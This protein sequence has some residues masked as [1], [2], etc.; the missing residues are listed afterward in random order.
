MASKFLEDGLQTRDNPASRFS[1][2]LEARDL[3]VLGGGSEV[4]FRAIEEPERGFLFDAR[5]VRVATV[6]GLARTVRGPAAALSLAPPADAVSGVAVAD[7]WFKAA[8]R[9]SGP[10][11]EEVLCHAALL[12]QRA[13]PG[14]RAT[15]RMKVEKRL[16]EI[17]KAGGPGTFL[18]LGRP[19]S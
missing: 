11:K 6:T 19:W 18:P 17:L 10:V 15:E 7:G 8:A 14:L 5:D 3:A 4:A 12:Y 1:L 16:E 2:L 9:L 13:L